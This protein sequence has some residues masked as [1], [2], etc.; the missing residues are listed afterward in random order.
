MMTI[1]WGIN[2][3]EASFDLLAAIISMGAMWRAYFVTRKPR[4]SW[5]W[6]GR[7]KLGIGAVAFLVIG[8]FF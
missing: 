3:V 7:T 6:N 8:H 5:R 4:S 1:K 2:S